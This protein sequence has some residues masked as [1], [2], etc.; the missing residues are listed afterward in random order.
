MLA[1]VDIDAAE[2][3]GERVETEAVID[4]DAVAFVVERSGEDDGAAVPCPDDG[5][6]GRAKIHALMNAGEL[7]VEGAAGAE[8]VGG[9]GVDGGAKTAGPEGLGGTGGEDFGFDLAVGRDLLELVR[10]GLDEFG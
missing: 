1:L 3:H 6:Q 9:R 4:H 5:A 7:A 2:V 8:A 10:V